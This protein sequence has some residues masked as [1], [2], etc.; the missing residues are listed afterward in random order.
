M[1]PDT[2]SPAMEAD[3]RVWKT[4]SKTQIRCPIPFGKSAIMNSHLWEYTQRSPSTKPYAMVYWDHSLNPAEHQ[5]ERRHLPIGI[6]CPLRTL[7]ISLGLSTRFEHHLVNDVKYDGV[8][9][10]NPNHFSRCFSSSAYP[11]SA[12]HQQRVTLIF[13]LP[14]SGPPTQRTQAFSKI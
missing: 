2:L 11:S 9:R 3:R 5:Q 7:P 6:K 8:P 14:T 4:I 12:E 13:A 1:D 10:H